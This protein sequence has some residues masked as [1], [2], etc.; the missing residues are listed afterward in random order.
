MP[1]LPIDYK[2]S[3]IYKIACKTDESLIYVGSTTDFTKRKNSHKTACTNALDKTHSTPVY[4]MIRANG[5]WDAF[6]MKPIKEFPCENKIQLV[7]EEE[8]IRKE[9]NSNLN[10]IR[11]YRTEDEK[12][13]SKKEHNKAYKEAN[14]EQM[15]EYRKAYREEHKDQLKETKKAYREEHKDQL[16]EQNKAYR[17]E[18]KDQIKEQQKSYYEANKEQIK[19]R[20]K[21]YYEAKKRQKEL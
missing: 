9:M 8:R 17:E 10:K 4:V 13:E 14:R 20:R 15:L 1:R 19:E 6:E 16:K 11:A 21:A 18:H 12:K 7:I 5:G 2:K 3:I